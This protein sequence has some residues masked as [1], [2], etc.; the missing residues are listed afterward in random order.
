MNTGGDGLK[1]VAGDAML[2]GSPVANVRSQP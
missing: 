1:Q 2:A